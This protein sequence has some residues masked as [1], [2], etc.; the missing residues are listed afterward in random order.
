MQLNLSPENQSLLAKRRNALIARSTNAELYV[1]SLLDELG[2]DYKAQKGF[3]SGTTH[4]IVDF[5]LPHPKRL[6]LEVDGG[7]HSDSAQMAYDARRDKF[8]REVR[9]FRVLRIT[10]EDAFA[11]DAKA[12]KE[13]IRF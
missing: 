3:L 5:Y 10:N 2:E 4:Y 9:G 6:C 12:L 11:L 1:Q 7:Y 8:L 13:L